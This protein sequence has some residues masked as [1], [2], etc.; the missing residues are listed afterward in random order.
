MSLIGVSYL[1]GWEQKPWEVKSVIRRRGSLRFLAP[2]FPRMYL[3][4]ASASTCLPFL[5]SLIS[6]S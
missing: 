1:W 4:R 6:Q 2:S 3:L 5:P